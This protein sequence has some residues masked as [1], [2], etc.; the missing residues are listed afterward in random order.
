MTAG[1][2]TVR[3]STAGGD[4]L[5]AVR[6][7]ADAVLYEGYL[8]YPYRA[9]SAKNQVRWQFGVLGPVGAAAAG[10]GEDPSLHT[11]CLLLDRAGE[12]SVEIHVRFLHT[13][14]R[15]VE[16]AAGDGTF[17]PVDE[18]R[19]G[20][21][22]W[23]AWHEAVEQESVVTG[24]R[25]SEIG[26]GHPAEIAVPGAEEVELLRDGAGDV[27]G[28]LVRTRW[29]LTVRLDVSAVPVPGHDGLHLLRVTLANTAGWE[30]GAAA[31]RGATA[32]DLAAR[33]SLV[34]T[35]LLL[36]ATGGS[37]ASTVDPPAWAADAAKACTNSR[38]WPVLAGV[39]DP[40][41]AQTSDVVLAAP[42]I[43]YDH[44][45]VAEE[46]PGDL[47]DSTEIDEI[48]T[49]RI[50]TMTD[51]EKSAA[52]GTD[53]RAAAIIDRCDAMPPEVFER[54]HGALRGEDRPFDFDDA[55]IPTYRSD[56]V[57]SSD[58][59]G[60]G[61]AWFSEAADTSVA[62][63]RDTVLVD[64]VAVAKGSRVRLRP[65]RRADAHDMF[66]ADRTAVVARVDLDVDGVTH[67]AV[68]LEDDPASD[69][70]EAYGRYYYFG[71]E[72][73]QP[74]AE[75]GPGEPLR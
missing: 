4:D 39:H 41:G 69:L 51:E 72:E 37:F 48:L 52:R 22:H 16:R 10:V 6:R 53:P 58:V 18:L 75:A 61:P 54:L 31:S 45:A 21:A 7:V 2:V 25:R 38:C 1:H 19:V 13:Q 56:V 36:R 33:H 49:L 43:L 11:E 59:A 17:T 5:Q 55:E 67:V 28:R 68:L 32:R 71:A 14:W 20:P 60:S 9:S 34:G 30:P 50:M 57:G 64:G 23:I 74:L 8:L 62:P 35:H 44:P 66:L 24:L 27:V 73:L 70:H 42:I 65:R 29:P 3:P 15:A 26:A 46:S 40:E 63:E 12:A 47:Y